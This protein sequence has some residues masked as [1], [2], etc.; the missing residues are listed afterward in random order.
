MIT[1]A[2]SCEWDGMIFGV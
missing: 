2:A 1:T